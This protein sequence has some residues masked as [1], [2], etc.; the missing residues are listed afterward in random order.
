[1]RKWFLA[2]VRKTQRTFQPFHL[3]LLALSPAQFG[4][5]TTRKHY[6]KNLDL[7]TVAKQLKSMF[8]AILSSALREMY[9]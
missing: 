3:A 1:M 6:S 9:V 2:I 4:Y 8:C 7:K 5:A